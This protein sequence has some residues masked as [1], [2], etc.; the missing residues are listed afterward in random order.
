MDKIRRIYRTLDGRIPYEEW[1]EDLRDV[2]G[3]AKIKVRVDRAT[4]GNF[5]DHRSLR[6]G[7]VELKI[8]YGPGY[9]LYMGLQGNEIIVL[10]CGG[11]KSTQDKDIAVAHL[12]W[13]DYKSRL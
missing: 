13:E 2:I 1:L 12:Y 10:L 11:N 7:I 3:R 8:N 9:R 6:G 5:G 4:L